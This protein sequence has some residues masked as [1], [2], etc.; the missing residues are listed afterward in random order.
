MDDA[1]FTGPPS[2]SADEFGTLR[3]EVGELTAVLRLGLAGLL[4]VTGS[5]GLYIFR[6]DTLLARQ[7]AAQTPVLMDAD[8]KNRGVL[9][10]VNEL[11]RFGWSHPD[12]ATNV[13]ARF[14]L[15]PLAPSNAPA[16]DPKR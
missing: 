1:P 7:V 4:V 2:P 8:Q 14:N 13:L 5:L 12:Y 11:Q 9:A 10:I 16:A 15:V 3:S 6:Q